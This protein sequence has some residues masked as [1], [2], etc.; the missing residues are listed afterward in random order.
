MS[1]LDPIYETM[2]VELPVYR[3]VSS[4]T[5]HILYSIILAGLVAGPLANHSLG[6][7]IVAFLGL[8]TLLYIS[9]SNMNSDNRPGSLPMTVYPPMP[10]M[11]L[12]GVSVENRITGLML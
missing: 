12:D 4:N 5:L 10:H 7:A 6:I 8:F 11:G 9:F 2:V 3:G 1:E